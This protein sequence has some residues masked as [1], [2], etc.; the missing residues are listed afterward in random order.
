MGK[1]NFVNRTFTAKMRLFS[2]FFT[3]CGIGHLDRI[4]TKKSNFISIF[5]TLFGWM[6]FMG[7]KE[8]IVPWYQ[9]QL[10][11]KG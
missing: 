2:G 4:Q 1:V 9:V 8:I 5:M 6:T 7:L 11:E 3:F 10:R